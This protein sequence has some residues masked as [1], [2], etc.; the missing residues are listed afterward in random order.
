MFTNILLISLLSLISLGR[1]NGEDSSNRNLRGNA[2]ASLL[3]V[4]IQ[5]QQYEG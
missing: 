5:Q 4:P 1:T 3:D 2:F